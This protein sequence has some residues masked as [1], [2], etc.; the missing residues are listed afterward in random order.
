MADFPTLSSGVLAYPFKEEGLGVA[1]LR[2]PTDAGYV[3]TRRRFTKDPK[4]WGVV[5]KGLT[6]AD[7]TTM[8]SFI[9][10]QGTTGKFNWEHPVSGD[11]KVVRFV[12]RP[13][14]VRKNRYW[15]MSC[16]LEEV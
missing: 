2:T 6:D 10:T 14:L 15:E 8:S 12:K 16:E 4:K 9:S 7:F 1:D 13:A 3:I 5:Y 11:T